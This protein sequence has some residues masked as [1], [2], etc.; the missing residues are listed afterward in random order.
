M[1]NKEE[2]EEIERSIKKSDDKI[3]EQYKGLDITKELANRK[4]NP[5]VKKILKVLATILKIILILFIIW[6]CFR[7]YLLVSLIFNNTYNR[8]NADIKASIER[9]ANLKINLISK[10]VNEKETIRRILF[11]NKKISRNYF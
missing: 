8:Y 10:N 3:R 5:K 11:S 6:L 9:S 1:E 2:W 4:K 7:V